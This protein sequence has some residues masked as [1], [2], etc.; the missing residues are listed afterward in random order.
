[1]PISEES[2][3]G[4]GDSGDAAAIWQNQSLARLC[5]EEMPA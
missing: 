3:E 2:D 1:M 5:A 4:D